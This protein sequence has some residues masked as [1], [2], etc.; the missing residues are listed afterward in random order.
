[1]THPKGQR[2]G[3]ARTSS[4]DQVAGFDAQIE[5]LEKAGV[6][7]IFKEQT[8]ALG[9]RPE[10]EEAIRYLREGD[11]LI[12]TALDR[13]ARSIRDLT[14]LT[15]QLEDKGVALEILGMGLNTRTSQ[16]QLMVNILGS[17]AQW[18]VSIM[19]ERQR[20]GIEKAKKEGRYKG[21]KATAMRKSDEVM[22][23][24]KEGLSAQKVAD[25]LGISRRSVF[26]IKKNLAEV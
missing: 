23:L 6:D 11:L 7:R 1:M 2:I 13:F 4:L 15:Q 14:N 8:S 21:R 10:L 9:I 22:R 12:V 3:Y 19:K 18:E 24:L 16:G 26:R 17:I 20:E 25:Q 5:A